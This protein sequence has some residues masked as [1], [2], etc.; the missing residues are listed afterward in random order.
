MAVGCF[1]PPTFFHSPPGLSSI[2]S[3]TE[4]QNNSESTRS[5]FRRQTSH[6][7]VF[8]NQSNPNTM[9]NQQSTS[10]FGPIGQPV[11]NSRSCWSPINCDHANPWKNNANNW[12]NAGDQVCFYSKTDKNVY[13][14]FKVLIYHFPLH[15]EGIKT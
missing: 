11:N 13:L 2:W 6:N 7:D 3:N 9:N 5:N 15:L 8:F 14:T 4:D 10:C 12:V 1:D